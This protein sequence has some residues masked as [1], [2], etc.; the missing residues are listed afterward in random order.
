MVQGSVIEKTTYDEKDD[1]GGSVW[2]DVFV[3][4]GDKWVVIRSAAAEVRE[5]KSG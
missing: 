3:K 2:M 5:L 4:R 1:S